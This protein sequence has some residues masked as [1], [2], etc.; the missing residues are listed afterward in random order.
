LRCAVSAC[1]EHRSI[2]RRQE[3]SVVARSEQHGSS[4]CHCARGR[5]TVRSR[6]RARA[7][8]ASLAHAQAVTKMVQQVPK[9]KPNRVVSE[10]LNSFSWKT[11]A[12]IESAL[13]RSEHVAPAQS[14]LACVNPQ[15]AHTWVIKSQAKWGM[16]TFG[17]SRSE[18]RHS[19]HEL[20]SFAIESR[21]NC[22]MPSRPNLGC[23]RK[24]RGI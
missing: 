16:H 11:C 18:K 1:Q 10:R 13:C 24:P 2:H 15:S 21:P 20:W 12:M 7:R 14:E 8:T 17:G 23:N 5:G 4:R 22:C 6:P 3:S 9:K 19:R